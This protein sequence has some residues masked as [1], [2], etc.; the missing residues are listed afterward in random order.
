[1]VYKN[2]KSSEHQYRQIPAKP[3]R[4]IFEILLCILLIIPAILLAVL[5][6][7]FNFKRKN[8]RGQVVL[9]SI[10]KQ[11][12]NTFIT[13]TLYYCTMTLTSLFSN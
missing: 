9:V 11:T 7:F 8:I 3:I 13:M 6:S 10:E 12:H 2:R 1:M 4:L 5:R